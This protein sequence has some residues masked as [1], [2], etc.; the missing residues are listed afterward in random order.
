L[1]S[2]KLPSTCGG[3]LSYQLTFL[4]FKIFLQDVKSFVKKFCEKFCPWDHKGRTFLTFKIFLRDGKSF[5]KSKFDF[6]FQKLQEFSKQT[7][8]NSSSTLNDVCYKQISQNFHYGIF[9]DFQLVIDKTTG[10]FNATKLCAVAK[11]DFFHWKRL[12]RTINL[13]SFL[14]DQSSSEVCKELIYEIKGDNKHTKNKQITGQYVHK[15]LILDI[16]SWISPEFYRR[17]NKIVIDYFTNEYK[18]LGEDEKI[19][20]IRELELKMKIMEIEKDSVI[21]EQKDKID[22]LM[23]MLKTAE[24]ARRADAEEARAAARRSEEAA[25]R[26]EAMLRSM[27]I[28]LLDVKNQNTELL[29]QTTELLE[30]VQDTNTKLTTVQKKLNIAVVDRAPLPSQNRKKE[31]FVLLKRTDEE[32]FP[33]YAVRG[34]HSYVQTVLKNQRQLFGKIEILLDF[35]CHPNSKTLFVRIRDSLKRKGVEFSSCKISIQDSTTVSEGELVETM[36]QINDE[37]LQV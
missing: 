21:E 20:K 4:T 32:D 12:A 8:M 13:I 24:E 26:S 7:K 29:D 35:H 17:C 18:T 10:Y 30:E 5:V 25:R 27:G 34:Q 15:D 16:A 11:K 1:E 2:T 33:Y 19:E 37:K 28:N 31:R 3:Q 14:Q 23:I 9:G 6:S 22:D 36:K